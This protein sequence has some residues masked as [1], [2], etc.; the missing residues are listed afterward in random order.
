MGLTSQSSG[1]SLLKDEFI[2]DI[3]LDK[4]I[5]ALAG[6]PNTGNCSKCQGIF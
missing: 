4:N 1:S 5:V 3:E 2:L 6:N